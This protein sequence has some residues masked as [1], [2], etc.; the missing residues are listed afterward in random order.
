MCPAKDKICLKCGI[1]GH[2][3]IT[4]RC[5]R[6]GFV[7]NR[8][9]KPKCPRKTAEASELETVKNK[10]ISAWE[11]ASPQTTCFR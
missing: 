5:R 10:S 4:E 6:P 11:I 7:H 1:L 3:K 2:Y 9:N 8:D